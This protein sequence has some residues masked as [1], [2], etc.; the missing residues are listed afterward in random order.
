MPKNTRAELIEGMVYM[1]SPLRHDVHALPHSLLA[2][3]LMYYVAKT[4]GLLSHGDNGTVRLDNDNEVQPDLYLLLPA[5]CGGTGDRRGGWVHCR[6]PR[7]GV[8]N[9][10]VIS[11]HRSIPQE[12]RVLPKW[13]AGI[14]GLANGGC[15]GRFRF[16]L[17][18][19]EYSGIAPA[20]DGTLCSRAFPGLCLIP[21]HFSRATFPAYSPC[22]INRPARRH[23]PIS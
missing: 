21:P 13:G 6:R 9:C 14:F 22:S 1:A 11:K 4:P 12:N 5:H 2:G 3:W 10:R 7:A 18:G 16:Y 19:G 8:R 23:M 20:A 17:D 15:G